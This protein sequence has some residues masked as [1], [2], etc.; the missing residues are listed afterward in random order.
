MLH[1]SNV[2]FVQCYICPMLH[3]SIMTFFQWWRLSYQCLSGMKFVL[4]TFLQF[5]V[6]PKWCSFKSTLVRPTFAQSNFIIPIDVWPMWCLSYQCFSNGYIFQM[7]RLTN[8]MLVLPM[9]VHWGYLSNVTFVCCYICLI[10]LCLPWC[11]SE[12]TFV[13]CRFSATNPYLSDVMFVL[14]RP[15]R[16]LV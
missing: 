11:F 10:N 4:H 9:F 2:T 15:L 8:V 5:D 7:W 14:P 13:Q 16:S 1:L 3:L 12:I 6:C